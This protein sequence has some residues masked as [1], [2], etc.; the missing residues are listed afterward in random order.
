MATDRLTALMCACVCV[1]VLYIRLLMP[2]VWIGRV[3]FLEH[4][5][6]F[7]IKYTYHLVQ[8]AFHLLLLYIL[9]N[10]IFNK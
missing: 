2:D 3:C 5:T 8:N 9:Y 10:A 7:F 4:L 6:I 1:C